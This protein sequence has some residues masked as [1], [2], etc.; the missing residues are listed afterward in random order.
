MPLGTI[1]RSPMIKF[2]RNIRHKL[3]ENN[4]GSKY[5]LYAV[6]EI[7]LVVIGILIAL[8]INNWNEQQKERREEIKLLKNFKSSIEGDTARINYFLH[9]FGTINNSINILLNHIKADHPYHDSLNFRF[10]NS[11]AVWAPRIDEEIFATMT[12]SD[13]NII[14]NED[15]KKKILSYYSFAKKV[16]DTSISRYHDVVASA[17]KDIF[18]TRFDG[19]WNT[20]DGAMIPHDFKAL[21]NDKIY[22]YFLKSLDKQLWYYVQ[23]PLTKGKERAEDLVILL[24]EELA[25]LQ[26]GRFIKGDGSSK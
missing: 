5:L 2:F 14:S 20:R 26:D 8:Q 9:E 25:L 23:D 19:L 17:S 21:K 3:L 12:A 22:N 6:G 18:S 7:L 11:T 1:C 24:N 4:R 15:L 10:L 13:L 16:F